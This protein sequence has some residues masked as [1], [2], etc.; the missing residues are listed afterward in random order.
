MASRAASMLALSRAS[1]SSKMSPLS[2]RASA[3][4]ARQRWR[5]DS[6]SS[7]DTLTT[8]LRKAPE[9][10]GGRHDQTPCRPRSKPPPRQKTMRAWPH[11]PQATPCAKDVLVPVGA[12]PE[13]GDQAIG[14]MPLI[15]PRLSRVLIPGGPTC[16]AALQLRGQHALWAACKQFCRTHWATF[17]NSSGYAGRSRLT[18]VQLTW[19]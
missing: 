19:S 15:Q 9:K 11:R 2:R 13:R 3:A 18:S 17:T 8:R 6:S 5:Q 16:C 7:F 1:Y 10:T 4:H 14:S 12:I